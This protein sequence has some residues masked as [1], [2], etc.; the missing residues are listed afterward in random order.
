L[1]DRLAPGLAGARFDLGGFLQIP[2]RRRRLGDEGEALVL[3]DGD[4]RRQGRTLAEGL[5]PG[6]ELLAEAHDVD[7]ALTKRRADGRRRGRSAGGHLQL[8]VAEN[9]LGHWSLHTM[10]PGGPGAGEPWCGVGAPP[11]DLVPGA[12]P[13]DLCDQP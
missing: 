10:T 5:R 2:G 12:R 7:A 3:V 9:L 6:V 1:A 4:H 13:R 11:T 8:D